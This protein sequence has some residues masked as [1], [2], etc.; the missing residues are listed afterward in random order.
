LRKKSHLNQMEKQAQVLG[1][2][3]MILDKLLRR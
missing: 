3:I 1:V 2:V